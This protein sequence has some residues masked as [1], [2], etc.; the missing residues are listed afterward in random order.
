MH[1]REMKPLEI[2]YHTLQSSKGKQKSNSF[3][4]RLCFLQHAQ[5]SS[6]LAISPHLWGYHFPTTHTD[7]LKFFFPSPNLISRQIGKHPY[8]G[9]KD[10]RPFKGV[11]PS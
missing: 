10:S 4:Q 3:W 5:V 2:T 7:S 8:Q 6:S 9:V 1:S 11:M